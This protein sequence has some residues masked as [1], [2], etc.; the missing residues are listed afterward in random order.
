MAAPCERLERFADG[1]LAAE[2]AEAFRQHLADCARCQVELENLLQLKMRLA[3]HVERHPSTPALPAPRKV[4]TR[5]P[6]MAAG[7][8]CAALVLV[9]VFLAPR[10]RQ[11]DPWLMAEPQRRLEMRLALAEAD[12]HRPPASRKMGTGDAPASKLP[13]EQ[14][15]AFERDGDAA[16][17]AAAL[18]ARNDKSLA[19]QALSYLEPLPATPENETHRAVALL[20][21]AEPEEAL[22][23][24]DR[25]LAQA[26]TLAQA[27]WN[28]GLALRDLDLSQAA[29]LSFDEVARQGEPGW[30]EEAR[31]RA[32]E[33]RAAE[34][35]RGQ[36]WKTLN[37]AGKELAA[38]ATSPSPAII[39]ERPPILRLFF[40]DAVRTRAS[41]E[42][43]RALLPLARELDQQAGGEVL[44]R[45]VERIA[46]RDFTH[47]APLAEAY[48]QLRQGTLP[49]ERL[50]PLIAELLRSPEGDLLMGVLIYAG[51]VAEHLEAFEARAEASEDPWFRLLALQERAKAQ[52]AR[53]QEPEARQTLLRALSLCATTPI[54]Y[55]CAGVD[56]ELARVST[57]LDRLDEAWQYAERA[58]RRARTGNDQ[59]MEGVA[60]GHFVQLS[61]LRSDSP[62]TRAYSKEYLERKREDT[63]VVR[64]THQNLALLALDELRF[65]QARQEIDAALAA[66]LPLTHVGA[67]AL[68]DIS[69]QRPAATDEAALARALSEAP[70]KATP[71][72][73]LQLKHAQARFTLMRDAAKGRAMLE[74]LLQEAEAQDLLDKDEDARRARAYTYSALIHEE[75]RTGNHAAALGWFGRELRGTLP[76]RCVLAISE[77]TERSL[78]IV[79]GAGGELLGFNEPA[80]QA[81][82]PYHLGG[83]VPAQALTALGGC[84]RV[85]VFA[86]PRLQ[87]RPGLL[88]AE[89]AWSYRLRAGAP[90]KPEVGREIHLVVKDVALSAERVQTLGRL[91]TWKAAFGPGG[92]QRLLTGTEATPSRVL[93]AMKDATDIDL[94]T[95]GLIGSASQF[96]YLVLAQ[97]GSSDEL[98]VSRI[99]EQRL[100][101]SPLVVLAACRSARATPLI[102]EP[103]SLPAAFIQAGARAVIASTEDLPDLEAASFFEA[104]R[105]RI[106]QGSAPAQ[107]LRDERRK[108][109]AQ[110]KSGKWVEGVLLYD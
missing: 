3:L 19:D 28:Q 12:R 101:R 106:R 43:V 50:Q 41:G 84:E 83:V 72:Q 7:L 98:S 65:D 53:G 88:P 46:S 95:H 73:R 60:L 57:R 69:R 104:L 14:L 92:E 58:W 4:F 8:A 32:A 17:L 59:F 51:A 11:G 48:A 63:E 56:L 93:A 71:G 35:T 85:E 52:L 33:L 20:M 77:D 22:R 87:G 78:I 47:R 97:E 40:Y 105:E 108:W 102:E 96:P 103:S 37:T 49:G 62:L 9:A 67:L 89:V 64:Y 100:E 30:A 21:K 25:A 110:D 39:A 34:Q 24:L 55:R 86:Q 107:A 15:A 27:L 13:L 74:Q 81:R 1:E 2:E 82:L 38:N 66:G 68:A 45:Y 23:H 10:S 80:R 91:N 16:G 44:A 90:P 6:V 26:P 109:L 79:R 94:V 31:Q 18:L 75:G 99:R 29:A 36:R 42:Q 70:A 61:R 5:W 54:E 76:E